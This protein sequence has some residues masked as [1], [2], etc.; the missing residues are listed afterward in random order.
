MVKILYNI[1]NKSID[2][3]LEHIIIIVNY[4]GD[5]DADRFH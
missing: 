4:F 1:Y 5:G 2:F 3:Y